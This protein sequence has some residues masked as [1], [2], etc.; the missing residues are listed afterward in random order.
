MFFVWIFLRHM[1]NFLFSRSENTKLRI[2]VPSV[3]AWY[4]LIWVKN[5]DSYLFIME[6]FPW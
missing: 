3:Y 4:A 2:N 1:T 5:K 6:F